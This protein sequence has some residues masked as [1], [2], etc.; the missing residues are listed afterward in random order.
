MQVVGGDDTKP[1]EFQPQETSQKTDMEP[2]GVGQAE[3]E[4]TKQGHD[5]ATSKK[6]KLKSGQA[7]EKRE[8]KRERPG[9]S[10]DDR[11]LGDAEST[12]NKKLKTLDRME[13]KEMETQTGAENENESEIYQHISEKVKD[14]VQVLD[15]ATKVV[16]NEKEAVKTSNEGYEIQLRFSLIN[17][18]KQKVNACRKEKM[19]RRNQETKKTW[20]WML[21]LRNP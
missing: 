16:Y 15:A 20:Q 9:K 8:R 1:N 17:R 10:D 4:G 7:Q 11:C 18:N 5:A 13:E 2:K 6:E 3:I 21:K 14:A 12:V 19:K